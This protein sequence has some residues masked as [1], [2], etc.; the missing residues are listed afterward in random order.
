MAEDTNKSPEPKVHKSTPT[1]PF[2]ERYMTPI[3]ILL[4]LI[5]IAVAITFGHNLQPATQPAAATGQPAATAV[6]IANVKT[7]DEAYV[8]N[9]NAPVTMALLSSLIRQFLISFTQTISQQVS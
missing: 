8:G 5:I 9:A 2:I 4:G 1:T 7:A 6:N 3:A